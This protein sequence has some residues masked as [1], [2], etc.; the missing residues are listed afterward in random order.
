MKRTIS[1]EYAK[2][3]Q[4]LHDERFDYGAKAA[5][6]AQTIVNICKQNSFKVVLDFGCGK[7]TL[8]PAVNALDKSIRV[9]EYDPAVPGKDNLPTKTPDLIVALDVMEHIEPD[10]L[11]DVLATLRDLKPQMVLLLIALEPAQKTLPDGRNAHLIIETPA[12]WK[13]RLA[14][15]FTAL[16]GRESK[17]HLLFAGTPILAK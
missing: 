6:Y 13:A 14:P 10:Y 12:W 16:P 3:N 1:P 8:K 9:L 11:D 7:G 4:Q 15:Y 2:L 5:P 17:E